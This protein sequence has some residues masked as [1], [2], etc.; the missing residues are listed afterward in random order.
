M[1]CGRERPRS[2][3][4]A[5]LLLEAPGLTWIPANVLAIA[6]EVIAWLCSLLQCMSLDLMWGTAPAPGIEVP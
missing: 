2:S 5:V 1:P 3:R 6:D 4:S